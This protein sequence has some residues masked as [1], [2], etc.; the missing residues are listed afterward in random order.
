MAL[1]GLTLPQMSAFHPPYA[2][3]GSL[4]PM[5]LG[6][7]SDRLADRLLPGLRARMQ[8][9]RFVTSMAVAATA[10]E[11][12]ADEIP[13]DEISTPAICFEWLV[14]EAFVRKEPD[15]GSLQGVPGTRKAR[16][17]IAR[18]ER[19]AAATYLKAPRVF[20]FNGVYKPFAV[21]AGVVGEELE[22]GPRC[23]ELV[24]AW[25]ADQGLT[26]FV[27]GVPNTS[28]RS[29]RRTIR[30]SVRDALR[31]GRCT[32][33]PA[34][35]LFTRLRQA[36]HPAE[37]GARER[38]L[39]RELVTAEDHSTRAELAQHLVDLPDGLTADDVTEA[40]WL[41][42]VRPHCSQ[43]LRAVV[44]AV[45][46]YEEFAALLD[47]AFRSLC[48]ASHAMGTQPLRPERVDAH[49][50]ITLGAQ[51]APDL[52]DRAAQRMAAIGADNDLEDRLGEFGI[53]RPPSE[54][55]ELLL[56]HHEQV[57]ARKLPHGKRSWFEPL[58]DGW[59]IRPPYGEATPPQLGPWFVHPV[60][61][62]AL[63]R[64]LIDT[65]S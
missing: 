35:R 39:L 7:L 48:A 51:K 36:L 41:A 63:R 37:A 12:L 23:A 9:I 52:Y 47:T 56:Q 28:G 4:D 60:R 17:A 57:Q 3:E 29:L 59:V 15:N 38:Q 50:V 14:V 27:D 53:P 49:E 64:F 40:Q 44:D 58:R 43:Q 5:G 24:R 25:E 42:T 10:C 16:G 46:A 62:E 19:L 21:D 65:A 30:E 34:S 18:G 11:D 1:A 45:V 55:V 22:P 61:V 20:G 32:T 13:H 2:G 26:G 6:A 54:F 33:S 31:A 8:R